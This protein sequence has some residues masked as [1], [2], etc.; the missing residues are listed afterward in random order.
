VPIEDDVGRAVRR[1]AVAALNGIRL[2]V[3]AGSYAVARVVRGRPVEVA[4][5][6]LLVNGAVQILRAAPDDTLPPAIGFA[7]VAYDVVVVT[8]GIAS[9]VRTVGHEA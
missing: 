2:V 5:N 8:V 9:M 7:L 6:L 3:D 1:L 4:L